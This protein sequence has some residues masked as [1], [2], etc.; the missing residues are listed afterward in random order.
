MKRGGVVCGALTLAG[1]LALNRA[2]GAVSQL[3]QLSGDAVELRLAGE[4]CT[5]HTE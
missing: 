4:G 2:L 3:S 1:G 5:L